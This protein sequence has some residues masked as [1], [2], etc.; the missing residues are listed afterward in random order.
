[1]VAPQ[2]ADLNGSDGG[3]GVSGFGIA[4]PAPA[5]TAGHSGLQ[6]ADSEALVAALS[7]M[8][9]A[10]PSAPLAIVIGG[11]SGSGKSTVGSLLA[12]RLGARFLDADDFHPTANIEKMARGEP[13]DD[14][15]RRPWLAALNQALF[16]EVEAGNPVVLACSALKRTYRD[17]LVAGLPNAVCVMLSGTQA[18]LQSRVSERKHRFMPAS[19]LDSQFAALEPLDPLREAVGRWAVEVDRPVPEILDEI[20]Q[21]LKRRPAGDLPGT[22][23]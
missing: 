21:S 1:M 17:R 7:A 9:G 13:L 19:L 10:D 12:Q 15:D 6:S 20:V 11:V 23:G 2:G 3:A 18:V 14:N 5:P 8:G 22:A 16:S 4:G